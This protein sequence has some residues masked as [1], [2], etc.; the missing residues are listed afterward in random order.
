MQNSRIPG[1]ILI[2]RSGKAAKKAGEGSASGNEE[3]IDFIGALELFTVCSP[4]RF[5]E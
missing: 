2:H 5:G 1:K 3:G 4:A